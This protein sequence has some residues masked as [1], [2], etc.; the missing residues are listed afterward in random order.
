MAEEKKSETSLSK[1]EMLNAMLA[2]KEKVD[3]DVK[4]LMESEVRKE[5]R[6]FFRKVSQ[7]Q[8]KMK[9]AKSQYNSFGKYNFRNLDDI[10][11]AAKPL[12]EEAGLVLL[13]SDRAY[14]EGDWHY[15]EATATLTDG[16]NDVSTKAL[17]RE[18]Q[19]R[20][21]FDQSQIT[22]ACS[23]YARKMA[24]SGLLG[25]SGAKDMDE[26]NKGRDNNTRADIRAEVREQAKPDPIAVKRV[27][28]LKS[29]NKQA[30]D[31]NVTSEVVRNIIRDKYKKRASAELTMEEIEDMNKNFR[32]YAAEQDAKPNE[33]EAK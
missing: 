14:I 33:P 28:L 29:V 10:L 19:D 5:R 12:L 11:S 18:V 22:G 17:S 13:L 15:I 32:I 2:Y 4:R 27:E 23:S 26:L 9:V 16:I 25:V 7:L 1:E 20:K 21:N 24:A 31:L 6:D 3:A 30:K 8:A